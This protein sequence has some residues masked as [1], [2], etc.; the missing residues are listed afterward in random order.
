MV[1]KQHK[2]NMNLICKYITFQ[3][4]SKVIMNIKKQQLSIKM[5]SHSM[6]WYYCAGMCISANA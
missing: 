1:S 5:L 6:Y 2:T 4:D 3:K